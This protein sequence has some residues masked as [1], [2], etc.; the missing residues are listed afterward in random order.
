MRNSGRIFKK[1]KET[2]VKDQRL[3]ICRHLGETKQIADGKTVVF[4]TKF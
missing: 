3:Q 4:A 2:F 1:P